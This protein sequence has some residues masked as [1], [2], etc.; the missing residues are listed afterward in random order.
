MKHIFIVDPKAF[1]DQQWKMDGLMDSI[2]QYFRTQEKPDFSTLF[3]HNPRD[4]IKLIQKQVDEAEPFDTV[5]VYSIGGDDMLFDCLNGIAGLPNMELAIAPYGNVNSFIRAFG[6]KNT[7]LFKDI[8][9]LA[10]ADTIPTDTIAVGNMY[11]INGCSVGLT[12]ARAIKLQ[13][14]KVRFSKGISR[15]AVGFWSFLYRLSS[16]FDKEIIARSYTITIDDQDYSGNYSQI[17]IINAP[18]FDRHRNAL[19]G[20]LPDDG[21]LDVVL[22]KAVSPLSTSLSISRYLQGKMSSNCVR[23]QAKKIEIKSEKPIYIKTDTEFL[24]D[25]SIT[26]EVVPGAAQVVTVNNLAYQGF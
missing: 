3:S 20:A 23:I 6:E 1:N 5:R 22:F 18:Y 4:A 13:E 10:T 25:T 16:L 14:I 26:F 12:S 21:V 2:G 19:A 11:A 8:A 17:N 24:L 9:S 7:G 15:Y